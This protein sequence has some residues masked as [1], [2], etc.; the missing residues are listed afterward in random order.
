MESPSRRPGV[1]KDYANSYRFAGEVTPNYEGP[2]VVR[3]I[4]SGGALICSTMDGE[5]LASPMKKDVVKKYFA[6]KIDPLSRKL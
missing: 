2:Y 4:F 6:Y 5:D 3:K 1:E